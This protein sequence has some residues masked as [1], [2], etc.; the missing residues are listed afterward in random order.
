MKQTSHRA[1]KRFRQSY[2]VLGAVLMV[3]GCSSSAAQSAAA[4]TTS[5]TLSTLAASTTSTAATTTTEEA[6]SVSSKRYSWTGL[7]WGETTNSDAKACFGSILMSSPPAGCTGWPLKGF[8]WATTPGL[9]DYAKLGLSSSQIR[10]ATVTIIGHLEPTAFVVDQLPVAVPASSYPIAQ[11][12]ETIQPTSDVFVSLPEI[13][14]ILA[15]G[16]AAQKV[17][18]TST[19]PESGNITL[20]GEDTDPSHPVELVLLIDDAQAQA[21]VARNITGREV[22]LCGLLTPV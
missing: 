9:D 6:V 1:A 8:D 14:G 10:T 11:H 20:A 2:V 19:A 7:V 3:A 15:A 17:W 16:Q 5:G 22:H 12:C 13:V 18:N 21:W 4:P